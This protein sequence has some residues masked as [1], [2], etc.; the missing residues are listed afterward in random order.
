MGRLEKE[1]ERD[2]DEMVGP[3]NLWLDLLIYIFDKLREIILWHIILL[4]LYN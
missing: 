3:R 4:H 1:R 2:D